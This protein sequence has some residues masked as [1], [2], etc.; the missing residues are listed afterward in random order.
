M[1]LV[2]QCKYTDR[3]A[4]VEQVVMVVYHGTAG[5]AAIIA[6]LGR[7]GRPGNGVR[8]S[9]NPFPIAFDIITG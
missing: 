3:V 2:K 6:V 9:R 4:P 5:P 8:A 7:G 1:S